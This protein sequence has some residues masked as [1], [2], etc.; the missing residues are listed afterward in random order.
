LEAG[1]GRN[2]RFDLTVFYETEAANQGRHKK[3][4]YDQSLRHTFSGPEAQKGM[5]RD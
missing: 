2:G 5:L 1:A 4:Y 3:Q